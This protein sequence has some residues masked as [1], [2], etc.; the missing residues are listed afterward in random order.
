MQDESRCQY[1][2]AYRD[3]DVIDEIGIR[4]SNRQCMQDVIISLMQYISPEDHIEIFIDGCDNYQFDL[5]EDDIGYDFQKLSL[6]KSLRINTM[7]GLERIKI[8]YRIG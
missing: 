1:T 6:E 3:A 8:N 4:E 5:S 2:F 7:T